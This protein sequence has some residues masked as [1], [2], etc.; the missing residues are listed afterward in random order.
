VFL[1]K[2]DECCWK[3]EKPRRARLRS[4]KVETC[5]VNGNRATVRY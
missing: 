5:V 2:F 3:T 4:W 1:L